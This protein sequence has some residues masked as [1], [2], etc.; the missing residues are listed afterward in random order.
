M[1]YLSRR[2]GQ[3]VIIDN[4]IEVRVVEVRGRIVKL[5]FVFPP[6]VSVLREEVFLEIKAENEEAARA[7]LDDPLPEGLTIGQ[8]VLPAVGKDA[9]MR[10]NENRDEPSEEKP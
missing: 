6:H 8:P 7:L 10:E 2:E 4:A 5:G 9:H 3:A 1:L